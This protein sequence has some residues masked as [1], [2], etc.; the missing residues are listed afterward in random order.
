MNVKLYLRVFLILF[1]TIFYSCSKK[2]TTQIEEE[3]PQKS[4]EAKIFVYIYNTENSPIGNALVKG[5]WYLDEVLSKRT[6]SDGFAIFTKKTVEAD[7][8]FNVREVSA[9]GYQTLYG[10]PIVSSYVY[11]EN[12]VDTVSVQLRR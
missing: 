12:P 5:G 3:P 4:W 2:E 9:A 10:Y 1:L 8:L 11:P 7:L 6:N